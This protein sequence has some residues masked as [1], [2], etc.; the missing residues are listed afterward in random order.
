MKSSS[1]KSGVSVVGVKCQG[2]YLSLDDRML[3]KYRC[4]LHTAYKV[5]KVGGSGCLILFKKLSS[6]RAADLRSTPKLIC[7]AANEFEDM[8][9]KIILKKKNFK[10]D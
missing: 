3:L 10:V 2:V 9:S 4:K 8:F 5:S 6:L 7:D 1:R